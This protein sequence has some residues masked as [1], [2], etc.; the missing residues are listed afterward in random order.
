MIRTRRPLPV[1]LTAVSLAVTAAACGG[2]GDDTPGIEESLRPTAR[3]ATAGVDNVDGA[4]ASAECAAQ[5]TSLTM[6]TVAALNDAAKSG[7]DYM[8]REHP[9]LTVTINGS[10]TNYVELVQQLSADRA[11]GRQADVAV[12]G[13]DLLP[14]F[15]NQLGAQ[16]FSPRLLRASYDQRFVKLGQV[17]GR[18]IGIPQQ[19]SVPVLIYNLDVLEA[20][21]V[22]P[23]TLA[24]TDGV[25]AAAEKIKATS[26]DIQP[27][28]LP[29]GEQF[30][31]WY[32]SSLAN[33]KNSPVQNA[34]GS[35]NV[36][37]P[38][39]REAMEFLARVGSYG[40]QSDS[41]SQQ[42]LLRFGLQK[43]TAMVGAT[44]ASLAQ[45]LR[46]LR[47]MGADGFRAGVAPF[48]V[49]PGG[50]LRPT[51]GGNAL[52]VLSTDRCQR[53]MAVELVVSLL[54][55]DVVAASTEAVSYLPVDT[56]A[57]DQLAPFYQEFPELVQFREIGDS[58]VPA[59]AW[60]GA[61]GGEVPTYLSEQVERAMT[62]GDPATLLREA[63]T[64][65][66]RLTS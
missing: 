54:A 46:V 20:A 45:G 62:G 10:A 28:D 39:A 29:V 3:D 42:G 49:L 19:V 16:E 7:K 4:K 47:D 66:T 34:D 5:V 6:Y 13:F 12:A 48:P 11:A 31:Q 9:G 8:E 32:L 23:A 17:D 33:S 51:A 40:P 61:R 35:P 14:T 53:E 25:L 57:A 58:L 56:A 50:T 55:P 37:T 65:I 44:V 59:P 26:P 1:L 24:T 30:G 64:E 27:I 2:G 38:A 18:Q 63:Q 36:D 43:Q 52:T 60:Q 22:D 21:G 15:A 41:P